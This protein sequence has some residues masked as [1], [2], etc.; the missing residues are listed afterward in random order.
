MNVDVVGISS[1]TIS[2]RMD[3]DSKVVNPSDTF[4]SRTSLADDDLENEM[5]FSIHSV[6]NYCL[7]VAESFSA[8]L[9]VLYGIF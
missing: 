7:T 2:K 4:S 3:I 1:E 9:S 5:T 8:T 6:S